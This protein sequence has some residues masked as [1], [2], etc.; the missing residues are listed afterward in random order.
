MNSY[1]EVVGR[2]EQIKA[3]REGPIARAIEKRTA[4]LPSDLYLW[5]AGAAV[6]ASAALELFGIRRERKLHFGP[7]R[8]SRSSAPLAS[9]V[10]MWVAPFLLFGIY[11]KIVKVAGSDRAEAVDVDAT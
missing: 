5:A 11:N 2:S 3:E 4:K 6:I 1:A 7:L 9:F 8:Q 10:G